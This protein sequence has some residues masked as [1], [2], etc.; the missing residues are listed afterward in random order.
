MALT[1]TVV[2]KITRSGQAEYLFQLINSRDYAF[3]GTSSAAKIQ[4]DQCLVYSVLILENIIST[5]LLCLTH[6]I[7][8]FRYVSKS[9]GALK[10]SV[11]LS[12]IKGNPK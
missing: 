7:T 1:K 10:G 2:G 12:K 5:W 9:I 3:T 8:R 6:L 11:D 4:L